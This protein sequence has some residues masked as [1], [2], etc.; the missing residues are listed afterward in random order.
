[1]PGWNNKSIG[2][3]EI[4]ESINDGKMWGWGQEQQLE[5]FSEGKPD[6]SAVVLYLLN[7]SILVCSD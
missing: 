4:K 3:A 2:C 6:V 1:M 5:F 7:T